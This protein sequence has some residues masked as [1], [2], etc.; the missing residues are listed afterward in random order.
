M[1]DQELQSM[2]LADGKL[3]RRQ[4]LWLMAIASGGV[5]TGCSVNPVTGKRELVLMSAS[6]ERRIDRQHAPHQIS[7]DY[8]V[9]QDAQLQAYVAGIGQSIGRRSHRPEVDYSYNALNANYIN[10]YAFPGGTIGITRG[11][12]LAMDSEAELAAL[13]GHEVGH[14]TARHTAQRMTKQTLAGVAVAGAGV[15]IGSRTSDTTTA[16]ALGLGGIAAGALLAT[17]SRSDERQAD[18]LGIEYMT[19]AGYSPDGMVDLMNMLQSLSN[20][21]PSAI[22]QM[23]SSHPM[24]SERY[25]D[26]QR[27]ATGRYASHRSKP[28]HRERYM[29]NTAGLRRISSA[30]QRQQLAEMHL[31]Q[32]RHA[33]AVTALESSL[34]VAPQDYTGLVMLG[35]AWMMQERYDQADRWLQ[36][37]IRV[38]P[39]E[40]QAQHLSGVALLQQNKPDAALNRFQTYK[41]LL[42]GN[43]NTDFFIG[44]SHERLQQ[45]PEAT[46]AFQSFLQQGG[47][48]QQAEY[49]RARLNSWG[50]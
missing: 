1:K 39:Q 8:G 7:A 16:L 20:S 41:R 43:P 18:S 15:A 4:L 3:T 10:A 30:I 13:I 37:A 22:E 14:V 17:Y 12:L 36:D 35:K 23:F 28:M 9:T 21:Q 11:I 33:D 24:S 47:S 38:Y 46:A 6:D 34:Q 5:M 2:N 19:R 29:D 27:E 44:V 32:G 49:A 31:G 48:G 26:A 40:A 42:P 25:R 50:A 45:I